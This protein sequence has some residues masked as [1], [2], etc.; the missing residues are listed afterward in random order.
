MIVIQK[1]E[2]NVS[3]ISEY[4][5]KYRNLDVSY[6]RLY[7]KEVNTLESGDQLILTTDPITLKYKD[8]LKE[9]VMEKTLTPAEERKY[10]YNPQVLSYDLYETTQY[11]HLLLELNEMTSA[12]EFNRTKIKV[13]DG[14]LPTVVNAILAAE[15]D[16]IRINNAEIN[17]ETSSIIAY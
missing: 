7:T 15:E 12:I 13:Y 11:W 6:D 8:D 5:S 1:S 2:A 17:K 10:F 3:T 9:I 14:S 16:I 4:C